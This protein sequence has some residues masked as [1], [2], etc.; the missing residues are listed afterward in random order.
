MDLL[1]ALRRV[2]EDLEAAGIFY[3]LAGGLAVGIHGHVRATEDIDLILTDRAAAD[4][5]LVRSGWSINPSDMPLP[6]GWSMYR[7]FRCEGDEILILDLLVP[8]AGWQPER[9]RFDLD[10]TP[11]W[12]LSRQALI[13]MKRSAGRPQDLADIQALEAGA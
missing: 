4:D 3:A 13:A 10:G 1:T 7:R 6:A 8:P 11:C 5:L 9:V 12:V 2:V